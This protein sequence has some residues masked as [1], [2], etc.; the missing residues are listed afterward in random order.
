MNVIMLQTIRKLIFTRTEGT[1]TR[2]RRRKEHLTNSGSIF[3]LEHYENNAGLNTIITT[4]NEIRGCVKKRNYRL[5]VGMRRL[6]SVK[7]SHS[8]IMLNH[9][10][11]DVVSQLRKSFQPLQGVTEMKYGLD[12]L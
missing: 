9:M 5:S 7:S 12:Q 10:D 8:C 2:T 1:I 6:L 11:A 3:H 4:F